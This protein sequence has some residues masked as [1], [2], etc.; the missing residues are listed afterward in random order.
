MECYPTSSGFD[1]SNQKLGDLEKVNK[2]RVLVVDDEKDILDIYLETL[3]PSDELLEALFK[4]VAPELRRED[5]IPS[6]DVTMC[7]Q[8]Q[9]AVEAARQA[10]EEKNPFAVAFLDVYIPPGPDG[11]WVAEHIRKLDPD[12]TLVMA[13]GHNNF[14]LIH[15]AHR[16]PPLDKLMY[17][18]KPFTSQEIWQFAAALSA[19]W[20]AER[21]LLMIRSDLEDMVE[22]RTTELSKTNEQ[23]RKEIETRVRAE[24]E[25]RSSEKNF[26]NMI[27]SSSDS[28]VI[29]ST[30]GVVHFMNPAAEILF[31]M[32]SGNLVGKPFGFPVMDGKDAEL[33]IAR[34]DGRSV[35]AEMRVV[36]TKWEGEPAYLATLRDVTYRKQMELELQES[37]SVLQETIQGTVRAMALAVET[38]DPYTAGH[39]R[40]VAQLSQRIAEEMNL[41]DKQ[42]Q[43]IYLA[44]LIHDIGKISVPA[45]IL[46]KPG[47]LTPDEFNLIKCHP[48]VAFDILKGINFPWPIVDIILQHHERLDGSGYPRGLQTEEI[49]A[50]ARILAVADV[51]EAMASHRPY[52]PAVGVDK[53]LEEISI[54][55]GKLYEPA[56]VNAC[57][58]LFDKKDFEFEE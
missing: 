15:L 30:Q 44:A 52:R 32:G 50:E 58:N 46:S 42:A 35:T 55:K 8:G 2:T 1:S 51:V 28:T 12:I 23:L 36:K 41:S 13:T 20:R 21:E 40:R 45:E 27:V 56:V 34:D 5:L 7:G 37:L 22:S 54:N 16:V 9:E 39:Q 25:K 14:D 4:N 29:L 31:E 48:Q 18:M 11:L 17:I 24:Q 10:R 57:L 26:R 43:G 19:K 6:F 3:C 53:A 33:E 38:R 49:L 47:R